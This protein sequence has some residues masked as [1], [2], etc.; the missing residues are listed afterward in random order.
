MIWLG[1]LIF[2]SSFFFEKRFSLTIG[3]FSTLFQKLTALDLLHEAGLVNL[4][5]KFN[6]ISQFD[7]NI[8]FFI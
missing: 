3:S 7:V 6:E 2:E 8:I 4:F 5:G 1:R